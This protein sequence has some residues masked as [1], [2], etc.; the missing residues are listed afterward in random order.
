MTESGQVSDPGWK[1]L[2][3]SAGDDRTA[4]KSVVVTAYDTGGPY[5][6]AIGVEV[7]SPVHTTSDS[8]PFSVTCVTE[9]PSDRA[10]ASASP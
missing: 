8:V 5:R 9:T 3:F 6:N 2:S 4:R 10:S 1:T 7:R